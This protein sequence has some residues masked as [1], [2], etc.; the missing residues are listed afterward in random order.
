MTNKTV[1]QQKQE[2]LYQLLQD[3]NLQLSVADLIE[4]TYHKISDEYL[5]LSVLAEH[6][7][8]DRKYM[9]FNSCTEGDLQAICKL[10]RALYIAH[11]KED[12][13]N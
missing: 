3:N 13:G 12:R 9:V 2:K 7:E 5:S 8:A 4:F 6:I 10:G 11:T 1:S